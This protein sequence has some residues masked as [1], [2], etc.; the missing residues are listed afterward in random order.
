MLGFVPS[1]VRQCPPHSAQLFYVGPVSP[2]NRFQT[3]CNNQNNNNNNKMFSIL[4]TTVLGRLKLICIRKRDFLLKGLASTREQNKMKC[5]C[6]EAGSEQVQGVETPLCR[7]TAAQLCCE[8]LSS[9]LLSWYSVLLHLNSRDLRRSRF[10][11]N[12]SVLHCFPCSTHN[13]MRQHP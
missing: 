2:C 3:I 5:C 12:P 10:C 7:S 6:R 11:V 4:N 8:S 1:F 13:K 9:N